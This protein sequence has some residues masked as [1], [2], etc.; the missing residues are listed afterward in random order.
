M[1]YLFVKNKAF[2]Q[3]GSLHTFRD[4]VKVIWIFGWPVDAL[5]RQ[6]NQILKC[7]LSFSK[8]GL[9]YDMNK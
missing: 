2:S 8:S 5:H 6:A 7:T 4:F 9:Q 3:R 1:Y